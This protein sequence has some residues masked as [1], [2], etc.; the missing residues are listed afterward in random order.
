MCHLCTD[1]H[2]A[3]FR[4]TMPTMFSIVVCE[5][6]DSFP[7]QQQH[8]NHLISKAIRDHA[9]KV[10]KIFLDL[11]YVWALV[12]G[13]LKWWAISIYLQTDQELNMWAQVVT[14]DTG[15]N[16]VKTDPIWS[17][18]LQFGQWLWIPAALWSASIS[19]SIGSMHPCRL[20]LCTLVCPLPGSVSS[21]ST[22]GHSPLPPPGTARHRYGTEI[23]R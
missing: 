3:V 11:K 23:M 13:K 14:G 9:K 1:S 10:R 21:D 8:S 4:S 5:H 20:L 22:A 7:Q 6:H 19:D 2:I 17:L 15:S 18:P 12:F 16:K